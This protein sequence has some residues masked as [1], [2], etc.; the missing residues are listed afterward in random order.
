M[1]IGQ[2][3][4]SGKIINS[5]DNLPV[6]GAVVS[7]LESAIWTTTDKNGDFAI[8]NIAGAKFVLQIEHTGYNTKL[9]EL[10]MSG[11]I[12]D[13]LIYLDEDNLS[14]KDVVVTATLE[15]KLSTSF[16][17]DRKALDHMQMIGVTDASALLP[18][19]KTNK[20]VH[21]ATSSPQN[22][23]IVGNSG[24]S[25][26]PAFGVGVEVDGVRLSNNALARSATGIDTR[27]ISSTNIE[28]IEIITGMP[29]VEYGDMTNG[30]VKINTR[31]G[32][33]SYTLDLLSKPNTKQVALSKGFVAGKRNAALNL[34]VEH[35]KSVS[36][37]AS[38]R[39]S[40]NRNGLSIN[41]SNTYTDKKLRPIQF[42]AGFSGNLG[43]YNTKSDP[44]M[45]VNTYSKV[46]D[47]I[48][49]ANTSAKW[50]LRKKWIT[51]IEANAAV[52]YNNSLQETS[53]NR[54]ASSS[55]A[56]IHAMEAGYFM[57][58][59]YEQ[60]PGAEVLL[61][62]PGYWYELYFN[63]SKSL[64][65]LAKIKAN[66]YKK[67]GI[68][69][70]N[71]RL[72]IEY[73]GSKNLGM[74][75]YYDDIRFA[76][77]WRPYRFDKESAINNYAAFIENNLSIPV[78]KSL[79]Q[80]MAGVRSEIT[81][82]QGSE[83]GNVSN[84]SPRVNVKYIFRHNQNKIVSDLSVRGGWG[85]SVK[86]PS[87]GVLYAIPQYRDILT[88]A[89]GTTSAGET[90]YAYYSTP[91]TRL[92]NPDLQWQNNIK[93]D[94]AVDMKIGG[95]KITLIYAIDKTALTYGALSV[96]EPFTYK[97]TDQSNVEKS[98]IPI[99]D[100]QYTIDR[101]TG[102]VTILDKTNVLP[103]EVLTYREF[104]RFNSTT[105]P[106]NSSDVFREKLSWIIDF[107]QINFIKT[108]F[109]IDGSYYTYKTVNE[110]LRPYM[111][112]ST[113]TMADGN[114]YKYIG[115]F[116][117]GANS[118]N[119]EQR[120]NLDINFTAVTHIPAIRLIFSVRLESSI[121]QYS[122]NLSEYAGEQRGFVADANNYY[123]P[124]QTQT[125]IYNGNQIVGLYPEY[126]VSTDDMLTKI[127]F[128]EKFLWAKDNNPALY[129][130]LAKM[131]IRSNTSY[132]FNPNKTSA[133]YSANINIT[134]EIGDRAT[135]TFN[136]INFINNMA[137]V[138]STWNG[139]DYTIF[140]TSL[141]PQ[142]YYGISLR[143]I[144]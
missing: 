63:D 70:N 135:L 132:Y 54:S 27:N 11:N 87:F 23:F 49:R 64:N 31:K 136:A 62:P 71:F 82:V 19:G 44:D 101:Q 77:T 119:G 22:F 65:Y 83:Y 26:N 79:L 88:F 140:D 67:T 124:S 53:T 28:S 130:E 98:S 122:Q 18:G 32:V 36:N 80:L 115:F 55:V 33:S 93:N 73:N 111:P 76:P 21:L 68:V 97:F 86:L 30:L 14:L 41:Y 134:K 116:V 110:I 92:Y 139:N 50:L 2:Y 46:K 84:L 35:T 10:L 40:Y 91:Y 51:S 118:A 142:F 105:M 60:N 85:K 125:N 107:R 59:T 100:R 69:N 6:R 17:I 141:I 29:S 15:K 123:V 45:F 38:P 1:V 137:K 78:K 114:P 58:Q 39:T 89:P 128:A 5:K 20:N 34:S 3:I 81:A 104:T 106:N 16:I 43:G 113:Q 13:T 66:W 47:N 143:L 12:T 127:P 99:N 61:I 112:N 131:V 121:Y 57:G 24:E 129:N 94:W 133:Y 108:A 95:N 109:R 144:F 48:L 52:N 9:M 4:L 138:R 7:M 120:K 25:G 102:V 103:S 56:A 90:F 8:D 42:D 96:Y 75:T 126:Y 74:G 72:G 37:I 117:G